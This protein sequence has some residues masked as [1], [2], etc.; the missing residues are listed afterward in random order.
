MEGVCKARAEGMQGSRA[1]GLEL[2]GRPGYRVGMTAG[3]FFFALIGLVV[4]LFVK[5]AF[6]GPPCPPFDGD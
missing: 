4:G 5:W 1:C 2:G 3:L 6:S